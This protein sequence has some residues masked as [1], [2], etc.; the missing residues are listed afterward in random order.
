M[1]DEYE[2]QEQLDAVEVIAWLA[3]Q[4][5]CAGNVGMF[6]KSWGGIVA[7]Q[8]AARRPPELKSIL[9][10][11]ATDNTYFDNDHYLGG[12]L[13]DI[14][15]VWGTLFLAQLRRPPILL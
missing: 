6:G 4:P 1:R 5:W 14:Q 11:C 8:V 13:T 12:C 2:E 10:V 9:S 3:R 15:M 7:L